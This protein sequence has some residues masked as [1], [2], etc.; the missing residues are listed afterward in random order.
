V[1][2]RLPGPGTRVGA[3]P[4]GSRIL[5]GPASEGQ[6]SHTQ[7]S[8]TRRHTWS[9]DPEVS[10]VASSRPDWWHA[11]QHVTARHTS[12]APCRSYP[13]AGGCPLMTFLE[14]SDTVDNHVMGVYYR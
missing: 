11:S 8:I 10:P 13:D 7:P 12:S 1:G 2:G 5:V 3:S 4:M 6:V 9:P 14:G